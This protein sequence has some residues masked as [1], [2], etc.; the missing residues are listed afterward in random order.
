MGTFLNKDSSSVQMDSIHRRRK[1]W[2]SVMS[3]LVLSAIGQNVWAYDISCTPANPTGATAVAVVTTNVPASS[4]TL[5]LGTISPNTTTT[6]TCTLTTATALQI[7]AIT[8]PSGYTLLSTVP[9][10]FPLVLDG[11]TTTTATFVV[12]LN[13]QA[14][15]TTVS[16]NIGISS[17]EAGFANVSFPIS[18]TIAT[19]ATGSNA[20]LRVFDT[21]DLSTYE[22]TN[23]LY[24]AVPPQT[25][26]RCLNIG[27]TAPGAAS[28]P[29]KTLTVGST[30][31]GAS[32]TPLTDSVTSIIF[33]PS[34]DTA[35][36]L[37]STSGS[38]VTSGLVD[39]TGLVDPIAP[40]TAYTLTPVTAPGVGSFKLTFDPT[41][42]TPTPTTYPYVVPQ[43]KL[44]IF[45]TDPDS[46]PA[47]IP[48][49]AVVVPDLNPKLQVLVDTSLTVAKDATID[50]GTAVVGNTLSKTFTLK[51]IGYSNLTLATVAPTFTGAATAVSAT[52]GPYT[53]SDQILG[54]RTLNQPTNGGCATSLTPSGEQTTFEFAMTSTTAGIYT[55]T[56]TITTNDPLN[57]SFTFKVKGTFEDAPAAAPLSP[58]IATF[59]GTTE[60]QTDATTAIDF[61]TTDI[62]T[63]ITKE[64]I[65]KNVGVGTEDLLVTSVNF[66]GQNGQ[67]SLNYKTVGTVANRVSQLTETTISI[68][69]SPT[70]AGTFNE[71]VE[72][73]NTDRAN[74]GTHDAGV[75][76]NPF[77]IQLKGVATSTTSTGPAL[78]IAPVPTNGMITTDVGG[79]SCGSTGTVCTANYTKDAIIQLTATP[80]TGATFTSWGGNC[81][82]TTSPLSVTMDVAKTCTATFTSGTTGTQAL[83]V[84]KTGNGT[85]ASSPTGIDCGTTCSASFNSGTSVTL[86]A[87]PATGATFTS[88][89]GACSGTATSATVTMDAAKSCTATFTSGTT[90][91]QALTVTKTGNGTVASSP[92]GID[93]GTTCS[94]SFNSGES[95]T[96]TATPATGATFTSWG[97][98]C[99]GTTTSATVTMDAAKSCTATFTGGTTGTQTLTIVKTGSGSV[100]SSPAGIN[101]GSACTASFDTGAV[102]TLIATPVSGASFTGWS[103]SCS[104]TSTAMIVT[105]DSAKSCTAAFTT[106]TS[107]EGS[108]FDTQKGIL[109]DGVCKPAQPVLATAVAASGEGVATTA[110]IVGGVSVNN[111]TTYLNPSNTTMAD[112]VVV[113]GH[114]KVAS[115][116]V[117]KTADIIVAGLLTIGDQFFWYMLDGKNNTC[118]LCIAAWNFDSRD[119]VKSLGQLTAQKTGVSLPA[120]YPIKIYASK[121]AAPGVLQLFIGYRITSG[122]DTGKL[123]FN[124]VP[125]DTTIKQ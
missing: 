119:I 89:G 12:R 117:G 76:E 114:I 106:T 55:G 11:T 23:Q 125:I 59:F 58:E 19:P 3:S 93:C 82:G 115:E 96:L 50:L 2:L 1:V 97:G 101:C 111:G 77:R 14:T 16:G 103:G 56:V 22:T 108:C 40:L 57:P 88:W 30:N 18:G 20:R 80:T 112:D 113:A 91:T 32:Y 35:F 53:E 75:A 98:A 10:P 65:I 44:Q 109:L 31:D 54:P 17:N 68:Q 79:I 107:Q 5:N 74:G 84:T 48:I 52:P 42:L 38:S 85:V 87:T 33:F 78:T 81:S 7:T 105:V 60:I 122:T 70:T 64:I 41:K 28:N 110:E 43:R 62:G 116:D 90:G 67:P 86:T 124:A 83:T 47:E 72:I 24:P 71:T 49:S 13:A 66:L 27:L 15:D 9:T 102:V 25:A 21:T 46:N 118:D 26:A 92:T 6:A 120:Y 8:V 73:F 36:G 51:N 63:P 61:G 37:S 39:L 4:P 99:S 104:G 34:P 29:V 121:F 45:S 69:F 123:V 94:A 95:V 100:V